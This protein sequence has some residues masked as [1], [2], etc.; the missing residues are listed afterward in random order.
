[1]ISITTLIQALSAVTAVLLLQGCGMIAS[2]TVSDS[3]EKAAVALNALLKAA[4]RC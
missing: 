4:G 1:M 3:S 2:K